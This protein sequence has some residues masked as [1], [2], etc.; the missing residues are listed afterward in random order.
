MH[1]EVNIAVKFS[2]IFHNGEQYRKA[3]KEIHR[4]MSRVWLGLG[5]AL[6]LVNIYLFSGHL[7]AMDYDLIEA[8]CMLRIAI[9]WLLWLCSSQL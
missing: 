2:Y 8:P 7:T 4:Q 1:S 9:C 3:T 6:G 5:L